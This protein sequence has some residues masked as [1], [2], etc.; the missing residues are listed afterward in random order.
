MVAIARALAGR[1]RLLL[2]DEPSE[3]IQ[4]SIVQHLGDVLRQIQAQTGLALLLV[5]QNLDFALGIATR[6]YVMEKG[7]IVAQGPASRLRT[8]EIVRAYL[9][10]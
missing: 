6:G 8:D 10:V 7:R 2:L 1:P 9:G 4:P 5:E 3:G